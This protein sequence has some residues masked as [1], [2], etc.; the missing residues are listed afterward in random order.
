MSTA[1]WFIPQTTEI[2]SQI[3]GVTE[4]YVIG[5]I[6]GEAK[7]YEDSV[8]IVSGEFALGTLSAKNENFDNVVITNKEQFQLIKESLATSNIAF[9]IIVNEDIEASTFNRYAGNK[10]TLKSFT[11]LTQSQTFSSG[12]FPKLTNIRS[13]EKYSDRSKDFAYIINDFQA[14][15]YANKI[16]NIEP[17]A[18]TIEFLLNRLLTCRHYDYLFEIYVEFWAGNEVKNKSYVDKIKNYLQTKIVT[19]EKFTFTEYWATAFHLDKENFEK[20]FEEVDSTEDEDWTPYSFLKFA[21]ENLILPIP[22]LA[23]AE[24]GNNVNDLS[25]SD[26]ITEYKKLGLK[27]KSLENCIANVLTQLLR[28]DVEAFKSSCKTEFNSLQFLAVIVGILSYV[29]D[30]GFFIG[31]IAVNIIGLSVI[32]QRF[33]STL[34]KELEYYCISLDKFESEVIAYKANGMS[35]SP[36]LEN[37]ISII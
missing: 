11:S 32:K 26:L 2:A 15:L 37:L 16:T 24:F 35:V 12:L 19:D 21:R 8:G 34:M 29:F 6:C 20:Y 22:L 30:Y 13:I 33:K 18:H 36:R 31:F 23:K 1:L 28:Q 7:N 5:R 25:M 27:S 4:K 10:L 9:K 14:E 3:D 17:Y